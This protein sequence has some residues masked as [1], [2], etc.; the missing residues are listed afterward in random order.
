M[1]VYVAVQ[2]WE[3][4]RANEAITL[5]LPPQLMADNPVM[6]SVTVTLNSVT[7]PVLVTVYV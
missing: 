5:L 1:V 4:P 7:V 3:A 2:V 6:G